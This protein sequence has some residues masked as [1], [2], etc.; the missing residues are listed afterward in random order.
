MNFKNIHC[1][2]PCIT[3]TVTPQTKH[4]HMYASLEHS[5]VIMV[6]CLPSSS[7]R[8]STSYK[9]ASNVTVSC[10]NR[11]TILEHFFYI[12]NH[13]KLN[14]GVRHLMTMVHFQIS[15]KLNSISRAWILKAGRNTSKTDWPVNNNVYS[16]VANA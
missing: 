11:N 5:K 14:V 7:S 13:N 16:Q 8:L 2:I 1:A 15:Y 4:T 12:K 9:V 3:K 6:N 10:V